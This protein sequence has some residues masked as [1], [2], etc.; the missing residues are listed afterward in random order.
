MLNR[1]TKSS[2]RRKNQLA[3]SL[4]VSAALATMTPVARVDDVF[5]IN[6][7]LGAFGTASSWYDAEGETEHVPGTGDYVHFNIAPPIGAFVEPYLTANYTTAGIMS[8]NYDTRVNLDDHTWT[9]SNNFD[10]P[11]MAGSI[12][13]LARRRR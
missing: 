12:G 5:L 3:L 4:A 7:G 6:N 13:M 2:R 1:G 8:H 10:D 11:L 9:L